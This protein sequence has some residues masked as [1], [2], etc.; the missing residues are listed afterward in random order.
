M[1]VDIC[2]EE[3]LLFIESQKKRNSLTPVEI[4][5]R[6]RGVTQN[7]N[8]GFGMTEIA[9]YVIENFFFVEDKGIFLLNRIFSYLL[10]FPLYLPYQWRDGLDVVGFSAVA[11]F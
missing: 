7:V 3:V 2:G 10:S 6:K 8:D 9:G 4:F 5:I 1:C 11:I